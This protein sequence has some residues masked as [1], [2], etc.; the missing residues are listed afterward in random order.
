MVWF[1]VCITTLRCFAPPDEYA[2]RSPRDMH[3]PSPGFDITLG[4]EHVLRVY[5]ANMR[6]PNPNSDPT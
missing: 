2:V 4:A 3:Q 5:R 1:R 6:A